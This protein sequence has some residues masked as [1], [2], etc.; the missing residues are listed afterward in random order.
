M[1]KGLSPISHAKFIR[2]LYSGDMVMLACGSK[3]NLRMKF[4]MFCQYK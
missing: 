1:I 4:T 2:Y 3:F